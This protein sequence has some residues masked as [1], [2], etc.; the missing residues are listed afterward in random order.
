MLPPPVDRLAKS[1]RHIN[2]SYVN[3]IDELYKKAEKANPKF[4]EQTEKFADITKSGVEIA[5]LKSRD[6]AT[7]KAH[8]KYRDGNDKMAYYRLNDIVR[9]TLIY[10]NISLTSTIA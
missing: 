9:G 2:Q 1:I 3:N 8:F 5:D 4:K 10:D 6:R 7:N